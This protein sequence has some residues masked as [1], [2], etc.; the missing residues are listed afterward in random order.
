[1]PESEELKRLEYQLAQATVE[2][3][4]LETQLSKANE[5]TQIELLKIRTQNSAFIHEVISQLEPFTGVIGDLDHF[6]KGGDQIKS[7]I[8]TRRET[9]TLVD[10]DVSLLEASLVGRISRRV[11][12]TIQGDLTH[13]W[14]TLKVRLKKL[15][16]GGRWTPE[17][18]VFYMLKERRVPGQSEGGFAEKLLVLYNRLMEKM[19]ETFGQAE[20]SQKMEFLTG[21]MKVQL[22]HYLD[23]PG[24]LPRD[25]NFI[26]CAH[27]LVDK[28]ERSEARFDKPD[29]DWTEVRS[30]RRRQRSPMRRNTGAKNFD[31]R[32]SRGTDERRKK[33]EKRCYECNRTGHVAAQCNLTRC[34]E[35]GRQGHVARECPKRHTRPDRREP[36][37]E[38]MDINNQDWS[39]RRTSRRSGRHYTS[40]ESS[41]E[42]SVRSERSGPAAGRREVSGGNSWRGGPSGAEVVRGRVRSD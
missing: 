37:P 12:N 13:S 6:I 28:S 11:L 24:S 15:Y 21:V 34:Y 23:K 31:K 17:E 7:L 38:P 41:G 14:E 36:P 1:M 40:E 27:D 22:N 20:G 26:E 3:E 8:T 18:D 4:K 29:S 39:S 35:C 32:P 30:S 9:G 19:V 16:G 42:E 10:S 5:R 2:R 25:R 33:P